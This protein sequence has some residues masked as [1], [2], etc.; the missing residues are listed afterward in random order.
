MG[1]RYLSLSAVLLSGCA[2]SAALLAGDEISFFPVPPEA[3]AE[4]AAAGVSG[5][6]PQ[7]NWLTQ[8]SDAK[9][10]ALV[11]EALENNPTLEASAATVR[12]SRA[13]LRLSNASRRP[14]VSASASAGGSSTSVEFFQTTPTIDPDTGLPGTPITSRNRER[15]TDPS[16]GLGLD[17]SWEVDLWGRLGASVD[18]AEQDLIASEADLAAARLAIA[19][20]TAI[21]WINLNRAL[22]QERVAEETF[23]AR[24]R[25]KRLTERRFERGL[26]TALD[27]RLA[28][29]ALAGAEAS[30]AAQRQQSGEATRALEVLL[31]RYPEAE[32][33]ATASLP[34]LEPLVPEG[35]PIMLLSRR[36]DVASA[37][38]SLRAAGLRAEQARLALL[39]SI[40]LT[41]SIS[42]NEVEFKD[43]FDPQRLTARLIASLAQP[44]YDGGSLKAQRDAAIARAE[45]SVANYASVVLTAWNEAEDTIA[46]DLFLSEQ[47]D[48]QQRALEE[49]RFAEDLAERQYANGLVSIFNLIDA[50]TRRLTAESNLVAVRSSRAINRIRFHQALGGGL[51]GPTSS[52]AV[53]IGGST[54]P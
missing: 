14:Q 22:A 27:V 17:A 45:A 35:N 1:L 19:A 36:P 38:A 46:A 11:A 28:R 23:T 48:A 25:T 37:E 16:F 34:V 41:G 8:F 21:A 10:E 53:E 12:A 26:S 3:P 24:D 9:M 50:Q 5:T 15:F 43:V 29:S 54:T 30:I 49:A 31:G 44:L 39:P 13:S 32:L 42:N 18:A 6:A 20:Q 47:E 33:E 4:W 51:L 40:R 52:N 7:G 2:S